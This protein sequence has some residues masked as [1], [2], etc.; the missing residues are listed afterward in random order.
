MIIVIATRICT[1]PHLHANLCI[2][3]QVSNKTLH[4]GTLS[5]NTY[6]VPA[7]IYS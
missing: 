2:I 6:M 1:Q 5:I 3:T 7:L 4:T